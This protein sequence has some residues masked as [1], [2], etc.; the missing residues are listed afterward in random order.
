MTLIDAARPGILPCQS[1]EALI[2]AGAVTS[3]TPFDADQVQ[4]ASLDL[5]LGGHAWRVRASFL[6]G[7]RRVEERIAD[8]AMHR[9]DLTGGAVL[10]KGCVYIVELQERLKLPPG[11]IAR[12]NPKSSTGRVDVFV[13]LLTD[14]G[15]AFDD[16]TEGYEGPLYLEVAPQTFSIL[17]RPGTRLNQLRL[18]AGDPP[19]LETRSVGVELGEGIVGF[20]GR[21]HA[22]VIDLDRIDGHD[23]RAYW[24]PLEARGGELLLDPG[25]FY[26]LASSDAVEIP[27]L[28]AAEMTPIDPSVGEFRVHYA[29]FFDPGFGTDEAHGA[30]SRGVLEVRTHD[31]PFLLEHGQTVARLVYEPLTERPTRLYGEGGSHYQSQGLKLSKH[32]RAWV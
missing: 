8:V 17:V 22:G 27:V 5:R 11:L 6:P 32:F 1:I 21:R 4:P 16:V 15:D 12:A 13:R 29:G 9:L 10:E 31:T 25:E 28:Q 26:I 20:R 19:R 3:A 7:R 30:G 23:P 2:A 24:E 14:R 18:K